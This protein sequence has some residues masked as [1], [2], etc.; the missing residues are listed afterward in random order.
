M[1]GGT[2]SEAGTKAEQGDQPKHERE[3]S[4]PAAAPAAPVQRTG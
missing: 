3:T 4:V 1:V 2:A